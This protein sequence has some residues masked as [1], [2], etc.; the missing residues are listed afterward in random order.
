MVA[1]P[2]SERE[3]IQT[4]SMFE[5]FGEVPPLELFAQLPKWLQESENAETRVVR[6]KWGDLTI[7]CSPMANRLP[8]EQL[9]TEISAG[10]IE[11]D[12]ENYA[13]N[14]MKAQ[15]TINS[16]GIPMRHR[17]P[18]LSP[19]RTVADV[20]K[21]AGSITRVVF[22]MALEE[23]QWQREEVEHVV[24]T[25][26]NLPDD[27]SAEMVGALGLDPEK[28]T[29][30]SGRVACAAALTGL[31]KAFTDPKLKGKKIAIISS[32]PSGHLQ[33][34]EHYNDVENVATVATF[35]DLTTVL[36]IDTNKYE[37]LQHK[38]KV[39]PGGAIDVDIS[40]GDS[41]Q[42]SLPY[43]DYLNVEYDPDNNPFVFNKRGFFMGLN[44]P[45]NGMTATMDGVE[46]AKFFREITSPFINEF[47]E[48]ENLETILNYVYGYHEP[49]FAVL[50]RMN[51][52]FANHPHYERKFKLPF[53]LPEIGT[54]NGTSATIF[55]NLLN[56]L[57]VN[58]PD[59]NRDLALF[60]MGIGAVLAGLKLRRK[61]QVE[62][63][64]PGE[65][66]IQAA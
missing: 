4:L 42:N 34:D 16:A 30:E 63:L 23:A 41:L 38:I 27:F 60:A 19:D 6:K 22:D 61:P 46:T 44:K 66:F 28:V 15:V 25:N 54:G 48:H 1:V 53:T 57:L 59:P 45:K 5:R 12:P 55:M 10:L 39:I 17:S 8:T 14:M 51:V 7:A 29:H 2:V 56:N 9:I 43:P 11:K 31:I 33:M 49:S 58:N 36:L 65:E 50:K 64:Y 20:R 40:Y 13:D 37:V 35:T 32:E 47:L 21:D 24:V 3:P 26:L 52:F 18:R 62:E